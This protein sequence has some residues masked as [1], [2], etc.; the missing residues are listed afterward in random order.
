MARSCL[1]LFHT[2]EDELAAIKFEDKFL[3]RC[4]NQRQG[5]DICAGVNYLR[6]LFHDLIA[7]ASSVRTLCSWGEINL[8]FGIFSKTGAQLTHFCLFQEEFP[9]NFIIV[10]QIIG[11]W[12]GYRGRTASNAADALSDVHIQRHILFFEG[13][14]DVGS[15]TTQDRRFG[16]PRANN[17]FFVDG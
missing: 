1:S 4:T 9:Y 3:S 16:L 14:G 13:D 10:I 8:V 7:Q 12:N 11:A 2:A 17:L 5:T 15:F 6:H